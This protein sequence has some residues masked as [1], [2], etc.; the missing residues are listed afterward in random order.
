MKILLPYLKL[1]EGDSIHDLNVIPGG[2]EYFIK[3]VNKHIEGVIP[4]EYDQNDNATEVILESIKR[5][6]PDIIFNNYNSFET[7]LNIWEEV[8]IPILWLNHIVFPQKEHNK[9]FVLKNKFTRRQPSIAFVSQFQLDTYE[10]VLQKSYKKLFVS[11]MFSTHHEISKTKKYD[12]CV[13]SRL[14]SFKHP[15]WLSERFDGNHVIL[16]NR[17]TIEKEYLDQHKHFENR[18]R[19]IDEHSKIM[20]FVSTARVNVVTCPNETWSISALESLERGV[21]VI[22]VSDTG[23]HVVQELCDGDSIEVIPSNASGDQILSSI[24]RLSQKQTPEMIQKDVLLRHPK[25]MWKSGIYESLST[26][27]DLFRGSY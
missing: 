24:E 16:S 5:H 2:R 20:E 1:Y 15:F 23:K 18:V 14:D 7:T 8:C 11:P 27:I 17:N 26:T 21:P 25:E 3:L 19:Y 10:K 6:S 12:A 4:V 13:V 22:V 9:Y